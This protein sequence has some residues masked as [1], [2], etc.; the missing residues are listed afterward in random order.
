[1]TLPALQ[2][3]PVPRHTGLCRPRR[4]ADAAG[5]I[6]LTGVAEERGLRNRESMLLL[7]T[8]RV[9][10]RS[11]ERER[12][13]WYKVDVVSLPAKRCGAFLHPPTEREGHVCVVCCC[14]CYGLCCTAACHCVLYYLF[15]NVCAI[16]SVFAVWLLCMY[17]LHRKIYYTREKGSGAMHGFL[18][19]TRHQVWEQRRDGAGARGWMTLRMPS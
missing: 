9:G 17:S 4:A 13:W 2:L 15:S 18:S 8:S 7:C 11:K 19:S 5:H 3:A 16:L 1:M 12:E 6:G 10:K 14:A